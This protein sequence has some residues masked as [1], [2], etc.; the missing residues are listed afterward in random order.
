MPVVTASDAPAFFDSSVLVEVLLGQARF[1]EAVDLWDAHPRRLG[2]VLI[3]AECR[4]VLRRAAR[5]RAA[6][7][8]ARWLRRA[9]SHLEEW[10]QQIT[11]RDVDRAVVDRLGAEPR[12][13]S[14]R[15][16]DALHLATAMEYRDR[17][18]D[19]IW[20]FTLDH[21]LG[22]TAREFGFLVGP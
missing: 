20:V 19:A 13:G 6:K 17:L 4:T 3:E 9:E 12:L 8:S 2:S 5:A 1:A 16:L 15:T 10:L 21:D 11:L 7:A 22:T 14:C 18:G